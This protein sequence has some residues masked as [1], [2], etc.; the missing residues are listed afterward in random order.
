MHVSA[1]V[2][3]TLVLMHAG[4]TLSL[5][6]SRPEVID[7]GSLG[8]TFTLGY[9]MSADGGLV[10]GTSNDPNSRSRA[11]QWSAA[12]G[13][14]SLA[15]TGGSYSVVK[16]SSRDGILVVG[17]SIDA[18]GRW[19][20][21]LWN[22]GVPQSLPAP[23]RGSAEATGVSDDGRI[24][25]GSI[26][27]TGPTSVAAWWDQSR[28]FHF[29]FEN[30]DEYSE[31]RAV[32]ADGNVAVGFI[33]VNSLGG[34]R[35]AF[36]WTKESGVEL[37]GGI[38]GPGSAAF[39]TSANGQEI[40][41]YFYE[42]DQSY[43]AFR[44]SI[45]KGMESLGTV[46]GYSSV[47]LCVS[48]DGSVVGGLLDPMPWSAQ[49]GFI[50]TQRLGLRPLDEHLREHRVQLAGWEILSVNAL[51]G[52]GQ[53]LLGYGRLNGRYA[54]FLVRNLPLVRGCPADLDQ[55]QV[56]E[57]SDFILFAGPYDLVL[58]DDPEMPSGCPAD[59]N[60]DGFVDDLDFQL[61]AVAYDR[62]I[63]P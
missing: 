43:R 61:F 49:R 22:N 42:S 19:R 62:L 5:A 30:T 63:C 32:S 41:G 33:E 48:P 44:W 28:S 12:S 13:M 24:I 56:V 34:R 3:M 17:Q 23:E 39:D 45:D 29:L 18:D 47:A 7:L 54:S 16:G 31:A 27:G 40:V 35:S 36:R 11:F 21:T 46:S 53:T 25:V 2:G 58:C 1:H 8:G 4:C 55:N 10:F 60:A 6:S 20:A 59:F 52:D 57:E 26:G 9:A 38:D 14:N 37:L 51:S 15:S 50:W